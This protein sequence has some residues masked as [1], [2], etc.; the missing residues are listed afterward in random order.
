MSRIF[1]FCINI[2]KKST[3]RPSSAKMFR[4][5]AIKKHVSF[6]VSQSRGIRVVNINSIKS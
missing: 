5:L 2:R 1:H 3:P 4:V 6:T